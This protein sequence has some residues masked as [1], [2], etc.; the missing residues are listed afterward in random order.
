M[1]KIVIIIPARYASTRLPGKPLVMIAGKP[2]IQRVWEIATQVKQVSGVY[3]ATDHPEIM[4]AV[5]GFGG[6]AIMTPET[7]RNGSERALAAI[8]ALKIKPDVVINLQGDAPVTPPWVVQAMVHD[9]RSTQADICTP[10]ISLTGKALATFLT[11]KKQTPSTG[12]TVVMD[13]S[14]NAL[15]FSKAVLPYFRDKPTEVFRHIGLYAYRT[16]VLRDLCALPQSPL[17]AAEQL[18]QLRALEN[19]YRIKV[20]LVDY[21]G[22]S[23]VSVD[24]PEDVVRAEAIIAR[25]GSF[26]GS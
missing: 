9:M 15:Y 22:R 19:G 8:D 12:T 10:A 5:K 14:G 11:E 16:S 25:E 21:R 2:M 7:C 17:E 26:D 13:R 20:A 4:E 18:E 1:T 3:V 24:T 23:S 6:K